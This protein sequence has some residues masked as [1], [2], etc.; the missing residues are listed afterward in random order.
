[1]SRMAD[2]DTDH[3]DAWSPVADNA[4]E[5]LSQAILRGE[6]APGAKISEPDIAK[7]WGISRGPLREAIR[8]LEERN[9]V[10]RT[11]RLGARVV[12]LSDERIQQIFIVREAIEGMAARQAALHISDD[13]IAQLRAQLDRQRERSEQIGVVAYLTQELDNDFHL[14]IARASRNDFLVKFLSENYGALIELCRQRQRRIPARAQ[15]AFIEHTRIV[16]ALEDRAPDVAELMMRR[17][18]RSA[19][20]GLQTLDA[21]RPAA[22]P[23]SDGG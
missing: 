21:S 16:D 4:L 14:A 8:R 12:I 6:F 1:M 11:P 19:Y 20:A 5:R 13:E 7:R 2:T 18:I 9:L 17:H 23:E 10:T 22:R 3:K 15:R